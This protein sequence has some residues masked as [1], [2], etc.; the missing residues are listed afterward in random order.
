MVTLAQTPAAETPRVKN[1]RIDRQKPP[2]IVRASMNR[3]KILMLAAVAGLFLTAIEH[4][5]QQKEP[6]TP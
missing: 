5:T 4:P 6:Q 1:V 2:D 3:F